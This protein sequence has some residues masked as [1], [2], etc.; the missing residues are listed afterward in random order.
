MSEF[1]LNLSARAAMPIRQPL[2]MG[3]IPP[4]GHFVLG[5]TS[6][7]G[8]ALALMAQ[9]GVTV[10]PY[11]LIREIRCGALS[12]V[13][14]AEPSDGQLKRQVALKLPFSDTPMQI[15]RFLRERD[16]LAAL[17]H[18][19]I[20]RLYD[21]GISESGQ[22]YL[23]MENV[24][25]TALLRSCDERRLTIRERL[26]VFL[27]VLEAV[28]FAHAGLI[29]H[30]DLQPSNILVTAE[31]RVVVLDFGLGKPLTEIA[32]QALGIPSDIYSLGV[33]LYELLTGTAGHLRPP[34][35]IAIA[36]EAATAR[37]TSPRSLRRMLAGDLDAIALKAL[38][39]NPLER[40]VSV[41]AFAEDITHHLENLPVSARPDSYGY[42]VGRFVS[43]HRA[44]ALAVSV[45]IVAVLSGAMLA[46]WQARAAALERDRAVALLSRNE[47]VNNFLD[48][49]ITEVAAADTPVTVNDM[50][51]R[52]ESLAL[53][54]SKGNNET[55]ATLLAM[56]AQYHHTL[57]HTERAAQ[58]RQH[59]S[60]LVA[61]TADDDLRSTLIRAHAQTRRC[62]GT[63]C[64]VEVSR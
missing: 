19:G 57:G 14:L 22:P 63:T 24:A 13:W 47:A 7:T 4:R 61:S 33:I 2:S 37:G 3:L 58:L 20:A 36:P 8:S 39:K 9:P 51:A 52:S 64:S 46:V 34:S 25:G 29:S 48:T 32:G 26:R 35:E 16:L 6:S 41:I 28:Q 62:P 18:P 11:R 59:V 21:A 27:Q 49:L 12:S 53:A 45:T 40:Y 31:G 50:L 56:I 1:A 15:E 38:N 44:P 30:G 23:A 5:N 60:S 55:R 10:G 17:T 54:V 43:R 42:R